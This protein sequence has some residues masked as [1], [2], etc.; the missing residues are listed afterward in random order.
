MDD[1][2]LL[3][4]SIELLFS[5]ELL[6]GADCGLGKSDCRYFDRLELKLDGRFF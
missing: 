6:N 1:D 4:G 5:F 3:I 2:G